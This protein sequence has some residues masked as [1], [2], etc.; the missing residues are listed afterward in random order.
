[1][2]YYILDLSPENS[3]VRLPGQQGYTVFM[4]SWQ[5]PDHEERDLGMEDY[6]AGRDGRARCAINAITGQEKVHAAGYCLG[7]TLLSIAAAAMA[8]EKDEQAG[9][10]DLFASQTDFK[11]AGRAV[12]V[13][14]RSAGQCSRHDVERGYLDTTQMAGAF[15]LLRSNDLIWSRLLNGVSAGRTAPDERPDGLE[16]GCHPHAV[17]HA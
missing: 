2:K 9:Q 1:M 6:R 3:L 17:S 7:G 11:R 15:Q 10:H 16:C 4:I 13:H 8:R 12:A 14:R 5:N